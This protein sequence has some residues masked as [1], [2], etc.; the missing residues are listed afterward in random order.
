MSEFVFEIGTEEI[1]ARFLENLSAA[2]CGKLEA[3]LDEAGVERGEVKSWATPRRLVV[4][5][6]GVAAEQAVSEEVVPGPP[7][8]IAFDADGNP[9]KAALGFAKTQ[10]VDLAD[11]FRL[12]TDKGEYLAVRKK[13]GGGRT[14]DLLAEICPAIV[15]GLAFPKKM[16]WGD[17]DFAFGRPVRWFLAL[18]G[19]T[20]VEFVHEGVASGRQT[21]G[22]RVMGPGPFEIPSASDYFG[23]IRDKGHVVLDSSER[24]E[25]IVA[26]ADAL[27]ADAGGSVV[28]NDGLLDE[29][30]GL[31]EYP[32]PV[33]GNFDESYLELP[34]EVLLTS[35]E[36]HQKS[37]G[38]EAADGKLL[39][40]FLTT[41][42]LEPKDVALVQKGWER[43]LKAR[44]EDARFFWKNDLAADPEKWLAELDNVVFMGP[45]GSMGDK[46][47]R[48]EK[49]CGW[50]AAR[51]KPELEK[52]AARAGRLSKADLVTEMVYE[53]DDL[54]GIMGGIYAR[55]NGEN[56]TVAEALYEQYLPAGPDT[57]VPST[58][59]GGI[60]SLAD[61]IDTLVGCFGL[62]MI[63]TGANDPYALRR[64]ALG[65]SR[66]ILENGLRLNLDELIAETFRVYGDIE[67]KLSAAEASEKL[68]DFF[69]RRLQVFLGEGHSTLAVE[70]A[71]GAG[72]N[73]IWALRARLDAVDAFSRESDFEQAVLTFKRAANI[74]R[75]QGAEEELTGSYD[76]SLLQED[77]ERSLAE[78]L[79]DVAPRFDELWAADAYAEL[80]GLLRELRPSVD[81][82]FDNVMVMCDDRAL[83]LN[84][85]NLLQ[86][87][88]ERLGRL[89]DFSALQV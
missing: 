25:K 10:G 46:T 45:L 41:L 70:A 85:L 12:E 65:I 71:V 61:K 72:I 35:M 17:L 37:F 55:R 44:L 81:A 40:H 82:F 36:S 2:L 74:I 75:K 66:I 33:L 26:D 84:R 15:H 18:F 32:R 47:R 30:S 77:A 4:A 28:W 49:L 24:R 78:A 62:G 5:A 60:V 20:V 34:R 86:S 88:V 57:P 14:V 1:P 31:V 89:A 38:I 13:V 6:S 54:Q 21:R 19:D 59:C 69:A 27:A 11:A 9:T 39:P 22:H 29:V 48:L 87:L 3:A 68:H 58:L 73:D 76:A 64:C 52:D 42:N 23:I 53:F 56:D 80:L 63:P 50:L 51:V 79:D 83:R 8:R 43:V 16:R 67:W 7:A